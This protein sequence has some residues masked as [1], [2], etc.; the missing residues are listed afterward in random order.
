MLYYIV[1]KEMIMLDKKMQNMQIHWARRMEKYIAS[2][3]NNKLKSADVENLLDDIN[4]TNKPFI[5]EQ[6]KHYCVSKKGF[7][8]KNLN[9][10]YSSQKCIAEHLGCLVSEIS[11]AQSDFKGNMVNG[12]YQY[13]LWTDDLTMPEGMIEHFESSEI[14]DGII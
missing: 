13:A 3:R 5:N 12:F 7:L 4:L 11:F 10:S 9:E 1:V 6:T 8:L 2:I 14:E